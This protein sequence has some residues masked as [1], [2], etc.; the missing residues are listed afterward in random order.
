MSFWI[1]IAAITVALVLFILR[2]MLA[3]GAGSARRGD[4]DL[5]VYQSQLD[6]LKQ[7]AARGV[8]PA[9]EARQAQ[10]EIERR[11]LQAVRDAEP[12][13]DDRGGSARIVA[14]AALAIV[15][16][17]AAGL[18]YL[19]LGRPDLPSK[20]LAER[21]DLPPGARQLAARASGNTAGPEGQNLQ[22]VSNMV[23]GLEERLREEPA[24]FE[25]W[26]LLGR[27]YAVSDRYGDAAAAYAKA[28]GLPEGQSDPAPHMQMGE[29]LIFSSGGVVTERAVQAFER[30]VSLDA[31]HPGARY[32]L[33]LAKGQAGDL[34]GAYDA[35][36]SLANDSPSDAPWIPALRDRLTEVAGDLGVEVPT[37]LGTAP[38]LPPLP[39]IVEQPAG[40]D[41]AEAT[42]APGPTAE[43]VQAAQSMSSDDRQAMIRGM[44]QRLAD[45]LVDEPDDFEGWMRL[46]RAYGVLG[47]QA[48]SM[49]AYRN[50]VRIRPNDIETRLTY[51]RAL[52]DASDEGPLTAQVI[53]QFQAMLALDSNNPDA[54]WMLGRADAE[55]GRTDAALAKW[56]KLLATQTPGS[57]A[58]NSVKSQID[59]LESK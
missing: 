17:L 8:I 24:N 18:L 40:Q 28:A 41:T 23:T 46:A 42:E 36:L 53:E 43:D 15:L 37:S 7:E 16:P 38:E 50:A 4:Y 13:I 9:A 29:A 25:G 35:W 47:N 45:R 44:V 5:K 6:D 54:L 27:S 34:Q 12:D 21:T 52:L 14:G 3:L 49:D 30:A 33:A 56:R 57:D 51:A 39:R 26:M 22:S 20:P 2:P 59:L 10:T 31:G 11:M 32:Y 58:W 1:I 19:E 55:A 48:G